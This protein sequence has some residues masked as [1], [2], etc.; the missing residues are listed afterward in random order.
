M[1][2]RHAIASTLLAAWL[3]LPSCANPT[4]T[5]T[6][7]R[8]QYEATSTCADLDAFLAQLVRLPHGDRLVRGSLGTSH[9][10]R[11]IPLV[12][13]ALPMADETTA[14]RALVVA[15]IHA[16]EIEGK[17]SVQQILREIAEGQ[18]EQLL[19]GCVLWFVPIY[20]AD[21]NERIAKKNRPEQNGPPAVGERPNAQG[22]DLNRDF[23]KAEAPE[24]RALLAAI[25]RIDPHLL[26]D[27]HTTDGSWHGYDLTYAPSL[28]TNC[29]PAVAALTRRILDDATGTLLQNNPPLRTFDYGN[30]ETRD[31]DGGGA[32]SSQANVRG[33]WTYDHRA[34]Y[35]INGFGLRN[36]IGILSEAYSNAEFASRIAS[37][38]AFTLSCLA[39]A[40]ARKDEILA[41]TNAADALLSE[42]AQ[43]ISFGY[44]TTFQQPIVQPVLVG[45]CDRIQLPDGLG[46][47]LARKPGARVEVMPVF[48]GFVSTQHIELPEAWAIPSPPPEVLSALAAHGV[49]FER[50]AEA[51]NATAAEFLVTKKRKPKRP[52]Q[53]HQELQIDGAYGQPTE[54]ML[55]AGTAWIDA[56]QPL[57]RL[58]ATLLEPVSEDSL[59]TWNFFEAMTGDAYPALR[60]TAQ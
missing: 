48:R 9:E 19:A 50:L 38:R 18:H 53:G 56:R 27:L 34:R 6:P 13:A 42:R 21:G 32:P 4:P 45:D 14:L 47:R 35:V 36:R 60:I 55:P 24:T 49:R 23:V 30:F 28:A 2:L 12:R 59:S 1:H 46:V 15:N 33:W 11:D 5:T 25:H 58:A 20:N 3:I 40:A 41:T 43:P 57:A 16:G 22:L 7:E 51:R 17:E 39:S 31:W 52:F 10:G 26:F 29:D 37:T 44:G 8:T 54:R